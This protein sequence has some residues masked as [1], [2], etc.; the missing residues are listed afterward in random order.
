[1]Y[2][3]GN[4]R[5][6][7]TK[8]IDEARALASAD[9]RVLS[10][11]GRLLAL[12]GDIEGARANAD[13]ALAADPQSA[14]AIALSAQLRHN[15]GDL[16]AAARELR[17]GL[18]LH[19]HDTALKL[20]MAG[21]YSRSGDIEAAARTLAE[22]I[23]IE[24][25][26]PSHSIRLARFHIEADRSDDAEAV[27]RNAAQQHPDHVNTHLALA[28]YLAR[29][30]DWRAAESV[31]KAFLDEHPKSRKGSFALAK[32]YTAS[33]SR[34]EAKAVYRVLAEDEKSGDAQY[35]ARAKLGTL[36]A[37]DGDLEGAR[38]QVRLALEGN[39]RHVGS[40]ELRAKLALLDNR[41]DDAIVDLRIVLRDKPNSAPVL[42]L[43]GRAHLANDEAELA[44]SYLERA[45]E[46]DPEG[47][48]P[49]VLLAGLFA[50]SGDLEQASRQLEA[51]LEQAPDDRTMLQSLAQ[52]QI[53]QGQWEAA[54]STAER[55]KNAYPDKAFGSYLSGRIAQARGHV[56]RAVEELDA[57]LALA[58]DSELALSAAV[59]S[60]V[61]AKRPEE[62]L[63]RV[64]TFLQSSAG[65]VAATRLKGGLLMR[66]AEH[67]KARD[68]YTA[69]IELDPKDTTAH[70]G[71][72]FAHAALGE[73][74]A[75]VEA[76]RRGVTATG[77]S[78]D[79]VSELAAA[80]E[81]DGNVKAV[82]DLYEE[83][84][85]RHPDSLLGA[86]NLAMALATYREDAESLKRAGE[87]VAKLED[88]KTPALLDTVGWVHHRRGNN[89]LAIPV[90]EQVVQAAPDV[91]IFRYHLAVVYDEDGR[92]EQ[93]RQEL[94]RLL[95]DETG[96]FPGIEDAR[97][98]LARLSRS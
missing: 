51:G 46:A 20:L 91:P 88:T 49:R 10:I 11:K 45:V 15:A 83:H 55:L 12:E 4:A 33:G 56:E 67:T 36:L 24:P 58:P 39:S 19:P 62:A 50:R 68:A 7:A 43:L 97:E 65:N 66:L 57:A 74:E 82:I 30:R 26:E 69:L 41:V 29:F 59:A 9:V 27:L 42:S 47:V 81:R 86:N 8:L 13:A 38:E 16:E 21:L 25:D 31:L 17:A 72:A 96:N 61:S 93:A 89:R 14:E 34:D 54:L 70:K 6:E 32:L 85:G 35:E 75:A 79:V 23:E 87:L 92:G 28:E 73:R 48:S 63:T 84:M 22:L 60:M 95:A 76:L 98:R 37:A 71:L 94:E 3:S 44:R 5:E 64:Q 80:Y 90:L 78:F 18:A 52:V 40:I 1:I 2:L 77:S 53:G